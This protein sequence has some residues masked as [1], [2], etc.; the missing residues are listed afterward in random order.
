VE[1]RPAKRRQCDSI[2]RKGIETQ[3]MVPKSEVGGAAFHLEMLAD[4]TLR[5]LSWGV[6]KLADKVC[7]S[8]HALLLYVLTRD[9]RFTLGLA[10]LF[11]LIPMICWRLQCDVFIADGLLFVLLKPL[12]LYKSSGALMHHVL[13]ELAHIFSALNIVIYI[14]LRSFFWCK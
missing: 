5:N 4:C 12:T 10:I 9:I 7:C 11:S 1:L 14:Y 6:R 8:D 2:A 13:Q 3:D